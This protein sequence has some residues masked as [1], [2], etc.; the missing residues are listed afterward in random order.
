MR[1]RRTWIES[2]GYRVMGTRGTSRTMRKDEQ[3]PT[4]R[5]QIQMCAAWGTTRASCA[6]TTALL[7]QQTWW[8][9]SDG[10]IQP[11][12]DRQ[13]RKEDWR[14]SLHEGAACIFVMVIWFGMWV[15]IRKEATKSGK[16]VAV[17]CRPAHQGDEDSQALEQVVQRGCAVSIPGDF[18]GLTR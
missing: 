1:H 15:R 18:Q 17:Y 5:V 8:E 12:Q 7:E 13:G 4:S 14:G 11:P 9:H 10:W 6:V 3:I 16:D 2:K